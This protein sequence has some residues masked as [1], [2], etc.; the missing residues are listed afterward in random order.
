MFKRIL[1]SGWIALFTGTALL[2]LLPRATV[3][4][5]SPAVLLVFSVVLILCSATYGFTAAYR[6]LARPSDDKRAPPV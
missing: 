2:F 5:L 6:R 3:R 4:V 1:I